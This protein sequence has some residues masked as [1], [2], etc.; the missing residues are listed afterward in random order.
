MR[1]IKIVSNFNLIGVFPK[2]IMHQFDPVK[3]TALHWLGKKQNLVRDNE[4]FEISRFGI[5]LREIS[6][7]LRTDRGICSRQRQVRDTDYL[8][9]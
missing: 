7:I 5:I 3:A 4:M 8:I 6:S 2:K 9:H 1:K